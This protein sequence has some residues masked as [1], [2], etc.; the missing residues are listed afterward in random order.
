MA[1]DR[2]G[3]HLDHRWG[4]RFSAW[5]SDRGL[6]FTDIQRGYDGHFLAAAYGAARTVAVGGRITG[7]GASSTTEGGIKWTPDVQAKAHF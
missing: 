5:S 2:R 6:T 7:Q 3:R 4:W 1:S